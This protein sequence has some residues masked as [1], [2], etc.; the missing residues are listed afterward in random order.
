MHTVAPQA[1]RAWTYATANAQRATITLPDSSTV[2]LNVGSRLEIPAD[3]TRGNRTVRLTG[4]AL[5]TVR[6]DEHST[7]AV[8]AGGQTARVLGTSFVVRH[9]DTDT[10]AMVAV[11]D[12]KVGVRQAVLTANQRAD[13]N[14]TGVV[15]VRSVTVGVFSFAAGVLTLADMPFPNAVAELNRWY[16]ADIRIGDARIA[17]HHIKGEFVTGSLSDLAA[18]LELT[19]DARVVR[20]GRVLTIYPRS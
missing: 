17:T 19:L 6:H 14:A 8:V 1:S 15:R 13:I 4:E 18:I 12:G 2:L 20:D 16:D 10:A 3:Y 11:R 5:F 7:F 9:Y